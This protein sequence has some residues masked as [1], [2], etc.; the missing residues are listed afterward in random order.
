VDHPGEIGLNLD[1][2]KAPRFLGPLLV[3]YS[4]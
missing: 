3:L 4:G 1:T 2:I